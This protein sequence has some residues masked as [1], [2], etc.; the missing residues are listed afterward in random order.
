MTRF[1][2]TEILSNVSDMLAI[3][4]RLITSCYDDDFLKNKESLKA[5]REKICDIEKDIYSYLDNN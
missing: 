3:S 1:E 5:I 2:E 4:R